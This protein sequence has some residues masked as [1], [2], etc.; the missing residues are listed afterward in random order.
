MWVVSKSSPVQTC[1]ICLSNWYRPLYLLCN[2]ALVCCVW[3]AELPLSVQIR[4]LWAT[5]AKSNA[6][7]IL[8][9]LPGI[10]KTSAQHSLKCPRNQCMSVQCICQGRA[11]SCCLQGAPLL[12]LSAPMVDYVKP[13]N[14]GQKKC[15]S[16][17]NLSSYLP[18]IPLTSQLFSFNILGGCSALEASSFR[19]SSAYSQVIDWCHV[20]VSAEISVSGAAGFMWSHCAVICLNKL[21]MYHEN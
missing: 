14:Q 8:D 19:Q 18:I 11:L 20:N 16:M 21:Y 5:L 9:L 1:V 4:D 2:L 10:S 6:S 15:S 17:H 7:S 12:F 3:V 13:C